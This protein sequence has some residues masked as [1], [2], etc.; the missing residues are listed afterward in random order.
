MWV[1][2]CTCGATMR[3]MHT[4]QVRS[5][6]AAAAAATAWLADSGCCWASGGPAP[7]TDTPC[8]LAEPRSMAPTGHRFSSAAAAAARES[9]PPLPCEP[10]RDASELGGCMLAACAGMSCRGVRA[11]ACALSAAPACA[12]CRC[13]LCWRACSTHVGPH[14][15]SGADG[16]HSALRLQ[17]TQVHAWGCRC[18]AANAPSVH[19]RCGPGRA[20]GRHG[21]AHSRGS[22]QE[23]PGV[24][25]LSR[26]AGVAPCT[27]ACWQLRRR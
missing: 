4:Q 26:R 14:A 18:H 13:C 21:R 20:A 6:R 25:H 24:G 8:C 12:S 2:A 10:L 22:V 17:A 15:M 1:H 5:C 23:H 7:D 3:L 11:A 27:C 16:A 9:H 19:L